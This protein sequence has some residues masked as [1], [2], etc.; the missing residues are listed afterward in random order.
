[1]LIRKPNPMKVYAIK[2]NDFFEDQLD[3]IDN[4][5]I[6][7]DE[8]DFIWIDAVN[9][10]SIELEFV[11]QLL[12]KDLKTLELIQNG[13]PLTRS[14]NINNLTIMSFSVVSW[15]EKI[16]AYPVYIFVGKKTLWTFRTTESSEPADYVLQNLRSTSRMTP[17]KL[18][19]E[20]LLEIANS[21]LEVLVKL[22]EIIESL[23]EKAIDE[24]SNKQIMKKVF[25]LK[26]QLAHFYR[27]VS[28]EE[29]LITELKDGF[30]PRIRVGKSE[31]AVLNDSLSSLSQELEFLNYYDSSLDGILRLQELGSIHKLDVRVINLTIIIAVLTIL[32]LLIDIGLLDLLLGR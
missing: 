22:R 28:S 32:I 4:L 21:N 15:T 16:Q 29:Q 8:A 12:G 9:L 31:L 27:L 30:I 3:S 19:N 13:L 11:S 23:E 10:N 18:L 14:R 2:K 1:M 24:P 17:I 25:D 20:L 7:E 5:K 6:I 26:R